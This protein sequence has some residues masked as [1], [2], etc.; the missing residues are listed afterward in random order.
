[1]QQTMLFNGC[2]IFLELHEYEKNG[3]LAIL[4]VFDEGDVV[5]TKN[6]S[7]P[8]QTKTRAYLDTNNVPGIEQFILDNGLGIKVGS[9]ES[10]W[11]TYPLYEIN[12]ESIKAKNREEK[13]KN[14]DP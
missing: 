14:N 11:C 10:G 3:T 1:M 8:K 4:M 7:S 13:N 12:V 9:A 6:L 2:P 5:I